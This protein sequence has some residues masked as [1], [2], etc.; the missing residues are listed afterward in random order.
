M[1]S[2]SPINHCP[3]TH[4]YIA[5]K[6][7]WSALFYGLFISTICESQITFETLDQLKISYKL[8]VNYD[9]FSLIT[10]VPSD[11][12]KLL[13]GLILNYIGLLVA[14]LFSV[15]GPTQVYE[16]FLPLDLYF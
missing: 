4:S 13:G 6:T 5:G 7:A 3:P 1:P 14:L 8:D 11:V 10:F 15:H 16:P 2:G 9:F 12:K